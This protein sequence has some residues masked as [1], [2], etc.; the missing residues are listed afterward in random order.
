MR[1]QLASDLHLELLASTWP[2][3]RLVAPAPGADVLVLA[4]DIDRGLRTIERFADWPV[5][6]L[7]VA[8]NHEFYD[9]EWEQLRDDLRD[10]AAGVVDA[11]GAGLDVLGGLLDQRA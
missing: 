11:R 1:I 2:Q 4:G 7:Y 5:P 3:E 9:H 8:G 6:V 10:R